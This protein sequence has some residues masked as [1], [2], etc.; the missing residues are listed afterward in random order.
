MVVIT[1]T[2]HAGFHSCFTISK[3]SI[4]EA[5]ARRKPIY[6]QLYSYCYTF[7][8]IVMMLQLF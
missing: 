5:L 6:T 8:V 2:N 1:I 7:S 3:K 4:S